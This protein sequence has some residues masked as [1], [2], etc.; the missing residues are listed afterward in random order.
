MLCR[1]KLC[2]V[3]AN[4]WN[5]S[6]LNPGLGTAVVSECAHKMATVAYRLCKF[7]G[8]LVYRLAVRGTA[9]TLGK[10]R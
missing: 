2:F 10:L 4:V 5:Y 7:P 8:V 1:C 6:L 3:L 9:L